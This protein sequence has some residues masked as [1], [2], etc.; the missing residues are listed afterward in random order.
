M[1]KIPPN[2]AREL[3]RR[4]HKDVREEAFEEGRAAAQ[5]LVKKL[6]RI[7]AYVGEVLQQKHD[8]AT[9]IVALRIKSLVNSGGAQHAGG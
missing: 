1:P 9:R 3:L 5:A 7:E 4:S 2:V 8:P 6:E